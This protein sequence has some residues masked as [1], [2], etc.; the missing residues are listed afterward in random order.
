MPQP[1]LSKNTSARSRLPSPSSDSIQPASSPRSTPW[2]TVSTLE[3]RQ[4]PGGGQPGG[5]DPGPPP[6]GGVGGPGETRPPRL[7]AAEQPPPLRRRV[8]PVRAEPRRQFVAPRRQVEARR[9]TRGQRSV[10]T[11]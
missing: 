7:A 10:L 3:A 6:P 11:E 5:D 9:H 1:A 2:S 4:R 8:R